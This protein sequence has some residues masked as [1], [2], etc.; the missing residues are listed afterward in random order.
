MPFELRIT[1]AISGNTNSVIGTLTAALN[2]NPVIEATNVSD[3]QNCYYRGTK[4]VLPSGIIK[5]ECHEGF[6]GEM[7]EEAICDKACMN[8]KCK[9]VV[10]QKNNRLQSCE[11]FKG[12]LGDLCD[13]SMD[14]VRIEGNKACL[15]LECYCL[16]GW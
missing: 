15:G 6:K 4:T 12:F 10:D 16:D 7:C 11:C 8:G 9:V 2:R 3:I 5:C 13:K 14:Q 1:D